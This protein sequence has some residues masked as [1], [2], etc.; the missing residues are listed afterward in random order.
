VPLDLKRIKVLCFDV[1]GTLSDTDDRWVSQLSR[2]LRPF[3]F[4][5]H[6]HDPLIMARRLIMMLESP[7]NYLY[8]FF[9]RFGLD[10]VMAR[11]FGFVAKRD[12]KKPGNFWLIPQTREVLLKLYPYYPMAIISARGEKGTF[13]FLNQFDLTRFF[14]N[15]ATSQTCRYTKPFPDPILWVA[16]QMNIK[17]EECLMIGDTTLDIRTGKSAGAQTVGVLCGFGTETELS[18]AGADLILS[19]PGDLVKVLLPNSVE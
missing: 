13:A 6:K 19:C 12:Q 2:F 10:G 15:V 1:D 8:H 16:S 5:S 9:D 17:P 11:F 18:R 7:G 14:R 4:L 3:S